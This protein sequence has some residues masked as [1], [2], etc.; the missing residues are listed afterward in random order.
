MKKNTSSLPE[1]MNSAGEIPREE[2]EIAGRHLLPPEADLP[3][4]QIAIGNLRLWTQA[5]LSGNLCPASH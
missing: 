2:G 3:Q 4:T 1:A 5:D